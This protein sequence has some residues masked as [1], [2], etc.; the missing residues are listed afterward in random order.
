VSMPHRRTSPLVAALP[1]PTIAAVHTPYM[2]SPDW[3]VLIWQTGGNYPSSMPHAERSPALLQVVGL[4]AEGGFVLAGEEFKA[5]PP[6]PRHLH[7]SCLDADERDGGI[8]AALVRTTLPQ[9]P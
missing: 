4:G 6:R 3:E 1:G 8:S 2:Q 9:H 5:P 7:V